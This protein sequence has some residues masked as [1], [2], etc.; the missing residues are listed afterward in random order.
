MKQILS[1]FIFISLFA[2]SITANSETATDEKKQTKANVTGFVKDSESGEALIRAT[3]QLMTPDTARMV[4][5]IT[6]NNLGG[7][8]IKGVNEGNYIIKISYLGYHKFFRAVTIRNKETIHNVGT[9][10]MTPTSIMLKEAVVTAALQQAV[11]KEDTIIF[12]ADAFK[13]EEGSVLEDLVKKLPGAQVDS[14]GKITINGKSIK[15]I[16][17]DGKEFFSGDNSTAM[18]NLPTEII[19]KI[20]TYDKASDQERLTGI[21]DGNEETVIDLTIKKGMKKGWFGNFNLGYGTKDQYANRVILNRFQDNFQSSLITNVNSNGGGGMSSGRGNAGNKNHTFSTGL[22]LVASKKDKYELGGNI[23]YNARQNETIRRSASQRYNTTPT[24]FSDNTNKNASHN[25][26]AN[27]EFKLE[28]KL[29]SLT[30]LLVRPVLGIGN[31]A[32]HG[33]G[34]NAQFNQ[35]PYE[36]TDNP[37]NDFELIPN[38]IKVNKSLSGSRSFSKN[39]NISTSLTLNHRFK[40]QGRNISFNANGSYSDSDGRNFNTSDVNYYLRDS[41]SLIYRFRNTPN[42]SSNLDLGFSYSEPILRNLILQLSYNFNYSYRK[43]NSD[44]YDLGTEP[45]IEAIRNDLIDKLGYLPEYD[46]Y[47]EYISKDLSNYT[48]DVKRNQNINLQ[49]RWNSD[50]ITSSV[51]VQ[52]QPQHQKIN[53]QYKNIDTIASRNILNVSPTINFRYRF[54]RQN[55]LNFSYRGRVSQPQITDLFA[56]TDDSN[57]L[58]IRL[59]NPDLKPSFSNNFSFRWNDYFTS[60]MQSLTTNFEFSNTNNNIT[61]RTEYDA[62]TGKSTS[63]PMNINGNWNISG[64]VG[65]NTPLF[66]NER[67][68]LNTS[69]SCSYN[70]NMSYVY[71]DQKTLIK[72]NMG[73]LSPNFEPITLENKTNDLKLGEHINLTYR[74]DTWDVRFNGEFNYR[75]Q[76]NKYIDVTSPNT[77]NFSYGFESNGN[78]SNGWGYATNIKMSSRRGY[79][80]KEANSNE[81]IW[82]AQ[83]SYRFLSG[84]AATLRL[85]VFDILNQRSNFSRNIDASGRTDTWSNAVNCYAMLNFTYRFNFFGSAKQRKELRE[86]R[87]ERNAFSAQAE[88]SSS[89]L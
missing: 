3:I 68:T 41:T 54:N 27:A 8:T 9:I 69:T 55:Q 33:N 38:N 25:D 21:A 67:L 36:F 63:K 44:T 35:D 47:K 39:S 74:T 73:Y 79:A 46:I 17:V 22:N 72:N 43:S 45:S 11:V 57:P 59:G 20:K 76:D 5:G 60:T 31:S 29:D 30:T 61:T 49:F 64:S 50:F 87:R 52:I 26:N 89:N 70:N 23:R 71:L 16:L 78:F 10:I 2:M 75:H 19:D 58:N 82:N 88:A 12:N 80:S 83:V 4:T 37:L 77:Y 6:T 51:G 15:K 28:W 13:V 40:K 65:F 14:D 62:E 56:I 53:Y 24:T 34:Q 7:F 81:L 42:T 84:R 18:K 66:A 85:Q 48:T 1:F 32:S 86:Q